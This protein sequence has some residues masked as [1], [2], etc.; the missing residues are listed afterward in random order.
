MTNLCK[1]YIRNSR[2]EKEDVLRIK[3]IIY[4]N[5]NSTEIEVVRWGRFYTLY[6][7]GLEKYFTK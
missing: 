5:L 4:F 1:I 3:E 7:V 2:E 6:L